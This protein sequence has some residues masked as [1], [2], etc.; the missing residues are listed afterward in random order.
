[1]EIILEKAEGTGSDRGLRCL[2]KGEK[3]IM[4]RTHDLRLNHL[5]VDLSSFRI[6]PGI[7]SYVP[8][9]NEGMSPTSFKQEQAS[10]IKHGVTTVVITAEVRRERELERAGKIARHRMVNS[11]LDYVIGVSVPLKTLT[12]SFIR[13]CRKNAIPFIQVCIHS[14]DEINSAKW[15]W[16]KQ[17]LYPNPPALYPHF[18][19]IPSKRGRIRIEKEWD[20]Q[21]DD[22]GINGKLRLQEGPLRK[23]VL[24]QIGIYPHK[25]EL[26]QQA[27]LDYNLYYTGDPVKNGADGASE[28]DIP[29]SVSP[30]VTYLRGVM[31]R[32]G[33]DVRLRP[34]YGKEL[35]IR[36]PGYFASY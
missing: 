16:I 7:V 36:L 11:S 30:D 24:K 17:A 6:E 5:K 10:L 32:A 28:A 2:I 33:Q 14:H 8:Q 27:D 1:M 13:N 15:G 3:V 12:P 4:R 29:D 19:N 34:G 23:P 31:L 25:G 21:M 26:I 22:H 35:T 9:I 20:K 18:K